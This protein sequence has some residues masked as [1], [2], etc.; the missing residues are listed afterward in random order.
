MFV[1]CKVIKQNIIA[2]LNIRKKYENKN[3]LDMEQKQNIVSLNWKP[4]SH[5]E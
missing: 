5:I 4:N 3:C 1:N 2:D